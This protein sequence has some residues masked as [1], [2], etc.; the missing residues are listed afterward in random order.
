MAP[1]V[2][3]MERLRLVRAEIESRMDKGVLL[4]SKKGVTTTRSRFSRN[5]ADASDYP[6]QFDG[7]LRLHDDD[8]SSD[9]E[10]EKEDDVSA[11][12]AAAASGGEGPVRAVIIDRHFCPVIQA[13]GQPCKANYKHIHGKSMQKH[14]LTHCPDGRADDGALLWA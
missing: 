4:R 10:D 7:W 11:A 9:D 1:A 3:P 12:A 5:F 13:S 2:M 14:V 6:S 8:D